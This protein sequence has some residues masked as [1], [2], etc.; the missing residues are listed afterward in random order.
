[1]FP[2]NANLGRLG[3]SIAWWLGIE[4]YELFLYVFLP[5]LLLDAAVRIDF[6]LFKR[7]CPVIWESSPPRTL[8]CSCHHAGEGLSAYVVTPESTHADEEI[9]GPE[10]GHD[11]DCRACSSSTWDR[12]ICE[13]HASTHCASRLPEAGHVMQAWVKILTLAFLVV[14][15]S[16]GLLIPIML[17]VLDLRSEGWTWQYCALFGSMVASTD[18]VAIVSTMKASM[19]LSHSAACFGIP[20]HSYLPARFPGTL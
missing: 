14:G 2:T 4:P 1:M 17:Y 12:I 11:G 16:C 18:A 8:L 13:S 19:W 20:C 5:P 10:Q 15:G 6:F 7:V 9:L 3:N